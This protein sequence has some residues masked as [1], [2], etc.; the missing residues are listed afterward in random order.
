MVVVK[1]T[2]EAIFKQAIGIS[3]CVSILTCRAQAP[4]Y[5][6]YAAIVSKTRCDDGKVVSKRI[7]ST[8]LSMKSGRVL[9]YSNIAGSLH[10]DIVLT[11]IPSYLRSEH[12]Y[13]GSHRAL[14]LS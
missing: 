1:K 3:I 5:A 8:R 4:I 2:N 11:D 7:N 14:T 9:Q 6:L 12:F 13:Q 10:N